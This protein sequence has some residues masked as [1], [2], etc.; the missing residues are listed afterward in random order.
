MTTINNY[1]QDLDAAMNTN[2]QRD[3]F[4]IKYNEYWFPL[5]WYSSL[6]FIIFFKSF[7]VHHTIYAICNEI[8]A[9][10]L[11]LC[12][13]ILEDKDCRRC[14]KN[15]Q[16]SRCALMSAVKTYGAEVLFSHYSHRFKSRHGF[17]TY[18]HRRTMI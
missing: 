18:V 7:C 12:D 16:H 6:E 5:S 14:D 3:F 15:A 17:G 4:S 2:R 13:K 9:F 8:Q 10:Y 1:L 11:Q